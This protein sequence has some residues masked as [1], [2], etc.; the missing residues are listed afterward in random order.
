MSYDFDRFE[1]ALRTR[2]SQFCMPVDGNTNN[3][4]AGYLMS[5]VK[6]FYETNPAAARRIHDSLEFLEN[7]IRNETIQRFSEEEMA[8]LDNSL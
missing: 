1:D 5:L 7:Q 8:A 2:A 3:Y 6:E 4:V